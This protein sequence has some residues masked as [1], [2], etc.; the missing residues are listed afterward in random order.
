MD[1]K[2]II[3]AILCTSL[4]INIFVSTFTIRRQQSL[5]IK[6]LNNTDR[7]IEILE[8]SVSERIELLSEYNE[9]VN[10]MLRIIE[11]LTNNGRL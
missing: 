6:S 8:K 9:Q 3:I 4:I 1:K 11:I 2:D 10:K 7:T 5:L